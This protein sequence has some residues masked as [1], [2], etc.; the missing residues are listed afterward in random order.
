MSTN[1][2]HRK[3]ELADLVAIIDL[4]AD[5]ELGQTRETTSSINDQKYID[6]FH[7]INKDSNQYLMVVEENTEIIGT[8]HLTLMP[9]LTLPGPR[10]SI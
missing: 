2:S 4:L 6:A 3:A 1:L 10:G 8:C 5:D 7:V 9:S